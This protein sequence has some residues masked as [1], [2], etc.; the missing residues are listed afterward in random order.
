MIKM[1]PYLKTVKNFADNCPRKDGDTGVVPTYIYRMIKDG[2][3]PGV[4][5]D[6]VIF[7]DTRKTSK[8]KEN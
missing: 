5:I 6:G 4:E 7:I 2:K 1:L 3:L 8:I